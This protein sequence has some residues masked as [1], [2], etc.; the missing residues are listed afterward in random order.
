M[1]S[2]CQI[3]DIHWAIVYD[4]FVDMPN[5]LEFNRSTIIRF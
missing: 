2:Y 3:V 1:I 5:H 4:A